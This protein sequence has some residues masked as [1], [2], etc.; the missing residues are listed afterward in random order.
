MTDF[1]LYGFWESGHSFKVAL[2]L[3]LNEAKWTCEPVRF[4]SGETRSAQYRELNIMGEAPVLIHHRD[5]GDFKLTQSGVCLTYLSKYFG[6]FG[7]RTEAEDYEVLRWLLFDTHKLSAQ[8]GLVRFLR[9]F[10]NR[11]DEPETKFLF[12]RALSALKILNASLE[13]HDWLV[14]DRP[15]IADIAC[16]SYLHWPEDIGFDY[17]DYSNVADWLDRIRALRGFKPSRELMPSGFEA[18]VMTA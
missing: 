5:D 1:T 2:M 14:G 8:A 11:A 4:G 12:N 15:T 6:T 10:A 9:K 17:S 13:G 7:P 18:A 16:Q 3:E